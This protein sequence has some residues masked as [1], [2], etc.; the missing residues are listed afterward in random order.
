VNTYNRYDPAA[1]FGGYKQ[2]GLGR[3]LG[4]HALE[5]YTQVKNVWID[6]G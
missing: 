6:L 1:P 3:D 5:G 4:M 2:S